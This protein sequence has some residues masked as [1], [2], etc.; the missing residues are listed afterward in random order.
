MKEKIWGN[1]ILVGLLALSLGAGCDDG[2]S[3]TDPKDLASF[4]QADH[5]ASDASADESSDGPDDIADGLD[6]QDF[7]SETDAA[8]EDTAEDLVLGPVDEAVFGYD[9]LGA[10]LLQGQVRFSLFAPEASSVSLVGDFNDWSDQA[11]PLVLD[12]ATG[13]WSLALPADGM[14]GQAYRF[15]IDDERWVVDP[16][17][18][19]NEQILGDSLIVDP[20]FEWSDGAFVR[21]AKEALVIYEMH[22]GDFTA[23]SSSG[24]AADRAGTYAGMEEKI[25][26][27][28]RL[29]V[30]AVELMPVAESQSDGYSWGYNPGLFFAPEASLAQG[31][32]GVQVAELQGLVDA[33]HEAGIAVI[34]DVVYNHV[35]GDNDY[36]PLWMVDPVYYFDYDDDGDPEDDQT[37]W[38][39][40]VA[41]WRPMVRK[42]VYDNMRYWM[43]AY[44]V[45]GFR[46]DS[47]ENVHLDSVAEIVRQLK[48][49]GYG[50]RY[51]IFEEF[52][53]DHNSRIQVH[54]QAEGEALISS[55]GTPYKYVLWSALNEGSGNSSSLG[56]V[57]YYS[58]DEGWNFPGAV[59][60]YFSSHDEGTLA[61]RH[62]ASQEEIKLGLLH[63]LTSLGVP[64]LWMGEEMARPH[65][66]NYHPDGDGAGLLPE[67][68]HLDWSYAQDNSAL[69]D[70]VAALIKLRVQHPALQHSE[71]DPYDAHFDW[72]VEDWTRALGT[73]HYG[74]AGDHDFVALYNFGDESVT[75]WVVFPSAG[76]WHLMVSRD[77]A[78]TEL[79]GLVTIEVG[80]EAVPIDLA[81]KSGLLYMSGAKNPE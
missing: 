71:P 30:N 47:T 3:S 21:P 42:L 55:W 16:Y 28:V 77:A 51:Y 9:L 46:L 62:E 8:E 15:V 52:S 44:H 4:D 12:E 14:V 58:H 45:D 22:V 32:D 7:E 43:D 27:L 23:H 73:L 57:T 75:F 34:V 65:Y 60:N 76:S 67:N 38:G 49:D 26:H 31:I 39:Y 64:M 54:N 35:W 2:A 20:S 41:T 80:V 66:G 25:D 10:Q 81:A 78:T 29:G 56:V 13:I 37:P 68:N 33:L 63:L 70:Y 36:N 6:A 40:K 79:P 72:V 18:L 5:E 59:I 24:V 61:G 50:E 19:A 11:N 53:G 69:V 48:A 74:V 17:A 1:W